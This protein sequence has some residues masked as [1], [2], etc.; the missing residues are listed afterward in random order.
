MIDFLV[1]LLSTDW[2]LPHWHEIGINI[3]EAKRIG[4]QQG[5][6]E[7]VD[8]LLEGR[9]RL[10]LA[11]H[12]EE[13]R[14]DT[15]SRFSA[16]LR[17]LDAKAEVSSVL[18]EWATLSHEALS[19]AVL[20]SWLNRKVASAATPGNALHLEDA[21]R[22]EVMRAWE[23]REVRADVFRDV[24]LK[25]TTP[26]DQRTQNI[27]ENP[28]SLVNQLWSVLLDRRLRAFWVTIRERLTPQQLQEFVAWYR[29][30]VANTSGTRRP[31]PLPSYIEEAAR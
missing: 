22:V 15:A 31:M 12:S 19:A 8:R 7:I 27:F 30:E 28:R 3:V 2:F 5:C 21:T 9:D 13:R 17:L 6:R 11:D 10:Y 18:Q 25:S 16:L 23:P 14:Q 24:C 20:C 29:I 26:W 1:L 4:I